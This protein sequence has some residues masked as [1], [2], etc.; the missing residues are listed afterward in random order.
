MHN[1]SH[2][3]TLTQQQRW[4]ILIFRHLIYSFRCLIVFPACFTS[5]HS[6]GTNQQTAHKLSELCL[7]FP[8][9][10]RLRLSSRKLV[11][12]LMCIIKH[13]R[14]ISEHIE[15]SGGDILNA[16]TKQKY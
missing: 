1:F 10:Y 9:N 4:Q 7:H 14:I 5:G 6:S 2:G 13:H 12:S 3:V 16:F 11:K 8:N 15:N